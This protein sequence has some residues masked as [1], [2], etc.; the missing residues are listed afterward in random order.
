V[1]AC[2]KE[3]ERE[4]RGHAKSIGKERASIGEK[5][6]EAIGA[7][8]FR[9][10]NTRAITPESADQLHSFSSKA[11]DTRRALYFALPFYFLVLRERDRMPIEIVLWMEN[12]Q[13]Q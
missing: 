6:K 11:A 4:K 10:Q 1:C 7:L 12:S 9:S 3:R 8:L 5:G 2:V 13:N